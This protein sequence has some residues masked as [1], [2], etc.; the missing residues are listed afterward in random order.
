M[1]LKWIDQCKG[2]LYGYG[3]AFPFCIHDSCKAAFVKRNSCRLF[4]LHLKQQQLSLRRSDGIVS[5]FDPYSK[6]PYAGTMAFPWNGSAAAFRHIRQNQVAACP[7]GHDLPVAGQ[8]G[9]RLPSVGVFMHIVIHYW[10]FCWVACRPMRQRRQWTARPSA[11]DG[12]PG[13]Q[14]KPAWFRS[15]SSISAKTSL[16]RRRQA[17]GCC[18]IST[19]MAAHTARS[20]SMTIS[21]TGRSR[22][23]RNRALMSLPSTCGVTAR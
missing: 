23:R 5:A 12:K 17:G 16:K 10:C 8:D 11:R 9:P 6:F 1:R 15:L 4:F 22:K 2:C 21:A 19:R 3:R 14:E 7:S 13:Y 20:C 18:S